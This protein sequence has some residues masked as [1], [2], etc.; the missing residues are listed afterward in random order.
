MVRSEQLPYFQACHSLTFVVVIEEDTVLLL[1]TC[2]TI[3][4]A[5][6]THR[7][8]GSLRT[9]QEEKKAQHLRNVA[10]GV[11]PG[12]CSFISGYSV[13]TPFTAKI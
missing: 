8:V 7:Y 4:S 1:P 6:L 9:N 13:D 12:V 11:G 5:T 3:L 10:S 2:D